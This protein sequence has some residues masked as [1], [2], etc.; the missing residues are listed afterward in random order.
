MRAG[1]V[2]IAFSRGERH[3]R[4]VPLGHRALDEVSNLDTGRALRALAPLLEDETVE[5]VGHDVKYDAIVLAR[6]GV[7]V[8]G[9]GFDTML[10]SYLLDSTRAPH[11]LET[12]S[13][14]HLDYKPLTEEGVYGKGAKASARR[15]LPATA[16]LAYAAERAD[17]PAA[18]GPRAA[19]QVGGRGAGCRVRG[20][21]MAP[22]AGA[23]SA[24]T[25]RRPRGCL[26]ARVAV[27]KA[28]PGDAGAQFEDLRAAGEEFN[29]NSPKQLGEILFEKLKLRC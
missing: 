7:T 25:G 18:V 15:N 17:S 8:A 20:P 1:L 23:R 11:A 4:Y 22:R 14:E 27:E 3:A 12:L 21:R 6:H 13:I 5:K 28:R 9:P 24:R 19:R 2:G 10:A 16:T 26:R 29:I